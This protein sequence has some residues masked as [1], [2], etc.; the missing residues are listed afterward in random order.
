MCRNLERME[1]Y[2]QD[3]T[4]FTIN[5]GHRDTWKSRDGNN[6]EERLSSWSNTRPWRSLLCLFTVYFMHLFIFRCVFGHYEAIKTTLTHSDCAV[7]KAGDSHSFHAFIY[8]FLLL[9]Q[10]HCYMPG[11]SVTDNHYRLNHFWIFT[12][13]QKWIYFIT[14]IYLLQHIFWSHPFF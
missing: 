10:F 4:L 9:A 1:L 12:L 14:S 8:L 3:L 2:I 6:N 7:P 11:F 13:K 5:R